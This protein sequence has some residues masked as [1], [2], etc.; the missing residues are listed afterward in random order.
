MLKPMNSAVVLAVAAMFVCGCGAASSETAP[1]RGKVTYKGKPVPN[2]TI[3]FV[4]AVGPAATGE[5]QQDG[6]YELTTYRDG[7][8]AVPGK[9]KVIVVAMRDMANLLPEQ[10]SPLPAPIVPEKYT[11]LAT[12]DLEAQV[13][14]KENTVDFDLEE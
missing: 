2:G 8:G 6:S 9:H 13:E 11:S 10:R 14:M 7:D 3:T 5:L 1:V 12:S 4:P